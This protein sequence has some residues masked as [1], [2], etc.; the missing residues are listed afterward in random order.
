MPS[1]VRKE[2]QPARSQVQ[3]TAAVNHETKKRV[4]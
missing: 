3:A 4:V 2:A 1:S